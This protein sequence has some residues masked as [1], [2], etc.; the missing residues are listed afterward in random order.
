V[1][2]A[3]E[4]LPWLKPGARLDVATGARPYGLFLA[5]AAGRSRSRIS[6]RD[7]RT[8]R[9]YARERGLRIE[10]REHTAELFPYTD[11]AFDLV[12]CRVAAHH[13]S[14]PDAFVR[15]AAGR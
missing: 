7:A 10:T 15:E 8:R 6:P 9:R 1:K 5:G 13:F 4:R 2:G 14:D 11:S 3:V 12:T